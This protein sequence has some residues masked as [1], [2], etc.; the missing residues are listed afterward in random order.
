MPDWSKF[1]GMGDGDGGEAAGGVRAAVA[2]LRADE[3]MPEPER[4]WAA[5]ELIARRMDEQDDESIVSAF[6]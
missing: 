4:I 1:L 6:L 2:R 5:I 3:T